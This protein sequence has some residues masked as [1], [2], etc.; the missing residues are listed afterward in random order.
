MT[1]QGPPKSSLGN[2]DLVH[3]HSQYYSPRGP[4]RK[5]FLSQV[6]WLEFH[7][8]ETHIQVWHAAWGSPYKT[9]H[10]ASVH[11]AIP[12]WSRPLL[13]F[14]LRSLHLHVWVTRGLSEIKTQ[15]TRLPKTQRFSGKSSHQATGAPN[16]LRMTQHNSGRER[17][18]P[19]SPDF[20]AAL[21]LQF[22]IIILTTTSYWHLLYVRHCTSTWHILFYSIFTKTPGGKYYHLYFTDGGTE[23]HRNEIACNLCW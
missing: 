5:T 4:Q 12:L 20:Q 11:P 14:S 3:L 17:H 21:F 16:A 10:S 15:P 2:T 19:R 6:P 9:T 13:P 1:V 22:T 23:T 8:D 18:R 7:G